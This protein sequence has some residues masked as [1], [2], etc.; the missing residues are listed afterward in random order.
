MKF[1]FVSNYLNFHQ[2]TLCDCLHSIADTFYFISGYC[3]EGKKSYKGK[4]DRDYVIYYSRE[5]ERAKEEIMSADAVIFGACPSKLIEM[6]MK[7][8]KLSFVFSERL[9]KRSVLQYFKP[10]NKKSVSNRFLNFKDKNLYVLSASG[11]LPYDLSLYNFPT[12]KIL[13]WGYFPETIK[14]EKTERIENS[15]LSAGRF[16]DWKHV[17]TAIETANLLKKDKI[18]FIMNIV[19]DG[20]EKERLYSLVKKYN[21]S[22]CVNFLG[23]KNHDEVLRLMS[24]HKIFMFTSN[25][26]EGWGAVLNEAM[27]NGCAVVASSAAGSTPYLINH[28]ENGLIYK[29]GN[30]KN[31]Y[32]TVKELLT[33]KKKIDE[34]GKNAKNTIESEYSGEIAADR[35]VNAVREFYETRSITPCNSG[36]LSGVEILKNNW[37]KK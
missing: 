24:I 9:F 22:D 23:L 19:G 20:P 18:D 8:N 13:K 26:K 25:F 3:G 34:L 5:S 27:S 35:F 31:A 37:F 33:D 2:T 15:I 32:K 6:R 12:E 16:L 30:D 4:I 14:I 29:Y 7:E 10:E 1:V 11:F 36:V 17:E 21:L 28:R